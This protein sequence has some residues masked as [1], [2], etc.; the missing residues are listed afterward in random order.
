MGNN[1]YGEGLT[2]SPTISSN[3][4]FHFTTNKENIISILKEGFKPHLCM[5]DLNIV[6]QDKP[7]KEEKEELEHAIPMVCFC[8]IPLSQSKN[9]LDT[10]GH[11]GIGLSKEWGKRNKISPVLYVHEESKITSA[12]QSMLISLLN[13]LDNKLWDDIYWIYC[14]TKPYEGKMWGEKEKKFLDEIY[15]FYDERER[16]Y[17]PILDV[18]SN[19]CLCKRDYL[20]ESQRDEINHKLKKMPLEF[21]ASDIKYII[22]SS[23]KEIIYI[24][25]EIGQMDGYNQDEKKL[26]F[27]RVIS[28]KQVGEDF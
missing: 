25:K 9:H 19:Y 8:D 22:V 1:G 4:L 13:D 14:F 3:T 11:C 12:V 17:V 6:L 27:S 21:E 7:T 23:E 5:E 2:L 16:R 18:L 15:R 24:I 10:Y 20:D 28:A 26:L